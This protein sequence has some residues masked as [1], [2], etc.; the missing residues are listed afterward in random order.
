MGVIADTGHAAWRKFET[1]GVP[2]SGAWEPDKDEIRTF[3]DSIDAAVSGLEGIIPAAGSQAKRALVSGWTPIGLRPLMVQSGFGP[4]G[5]IMSHTPMQYATVRRPR[6]INP[7]HVYCAPGASGAGTRFDPCAPSVAF[8]NSTAEFVHLYSGTYD[9]FGMSYTDPA[10]A[11]AN[12]IRPKLLIADDAVTWRAAGPDISAAT[13]TLH[14][15]NVWK[16][17]ALSVIG[18]QQPHHVYRLDNYDPE[19]GMPVRPLQF[20]TPGALV[21]ATTQQGWA[22]D[23]A[24]KQLYLRLSDLAGG[25]LDV[26]SYRSQV[27][28]LWGSAGT[29]AQCLSNG[30]PVGLFG[31]MAFMGVQVVAQN[32]GSVNADLYMDGGPGKILSFCSQD[33]GIQTFGGYTYLKNVKV[34]GSQFDAFNYNPGVGTSSAAYCTEVDC[35]A[36]AAGDVMTYGGP[37]TARTANCNGSSA[38]GG[39]QIFR[40]GGF[41]A[42]GWGPQIADVGAGTSWNIRNIVRDT[43]DPQEIGYVFETGRV[44]YLDQCISQSNN[45]SIQTVG[46]TTKQ[47]GGS[48]D[49]TITGVG[50]YNV[51]TGA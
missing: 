15:S 35:E 16:T 37:G 33:A 34:H 3:V 25:W 42:G 5:V 50:T 43:E 36:T 44:A 4:G 2:G 9:P 6:F 46:A 20:A 27:S 1:D 19:F 10:H 30:V 17:A 18:S 47:F 41:Y 21:T 28:A 23:N 13:W 45:I 14:G 31:P 22:W 7:T 8:N 51:V 39:C 12:G 11:G 32:A 48:F 29:V 38:H 49:G 40:A 24:T 26:N